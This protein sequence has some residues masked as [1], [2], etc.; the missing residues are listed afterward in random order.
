MCCV[1]LSHTHVFVCGILDNLPNIIK[2]LF[3]SCSNP[4]INSVLEIWSGKGF[5]VRSICSSAVCF[6]FAG[7]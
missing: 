6:V 7:V 2:C 1:A 5:V 3:S 4:E